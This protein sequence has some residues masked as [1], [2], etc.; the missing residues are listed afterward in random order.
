MMEAI[1]KMT[2]KKRA[3]SKEQYKKIN[4][5]NESPSDIHELSFGEIPEC[6]ND[7]GAIKYWN[8][9]KHAYHVD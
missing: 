4:Q 8:L 6:P 9:N 5:M 2:A 7:N 3:A 1:Q